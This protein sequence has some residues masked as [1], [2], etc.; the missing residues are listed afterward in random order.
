MENIFRPVYLLLLQKE[1]TQQTFL[2]KANR[3]GNELYV[4]DAH[5]APNIMRE[6]GRLREIAFRKCGGVTG[7]SADIDEF[8]FMSF[9]CCAGFKIIS[10]EYRASR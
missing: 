1:L 6:I 2:R 10:G 8:D 3:G 7:K 9:L 4:T 5:S